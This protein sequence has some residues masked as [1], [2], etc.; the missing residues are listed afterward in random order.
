MRD[1]GKL[2]VVAGTRPEAIKL[3]PLIV[4]FRRRG[5]PVTLCATGQ[6]RELFDQALA[7]FDLRPDIDLALMRPGQSV[8]GFMARALTAL[9]PLLRADRERP[10]GPHR[11]A[12]RD[13]PARRMRKL[14][15][16]V[17]L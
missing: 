15:H 3:A 12:R 5:L 17:R 14:L 10:P 6:H 11:K 7:Y 13:L 16:I 2:M 4:E 1:G 8:D 9:G